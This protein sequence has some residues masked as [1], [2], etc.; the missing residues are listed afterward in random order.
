M[1]PVE[2]IT[3]N[4]SGQRFATAIPTLV[5]KCQY[6]RDFFRSDWKAALQDDGA[7]FVDSN[8]EVF[9][10]ILN[11][12]RR[13]VFPLSYDQ[14]KGH[15][16]K[17][18]AEV[19]AEARHFRIPKLERWLADQLYLNCITSSTVWS[20]AFKDDTLQEGFQTTSTWRSDVIS[21]QLVRNDINVTRRYVCS[22]VTGGR[23]I[24]TKKYCS[25]GAETMKDDL[26]TYRWAEVG[27][28]LTFHHGWCSDT[29]KEF[30]E[31]WE[32]ISR[33]TPPGKS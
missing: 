10:H 5:D 16:Y 32:R 24:C 22:H 13:G 17:L 9:R 33:P 30:V 1:Y 28:S 14:K 23:N 21:T 4:V 19:L 6:F 26:E 15:D 27:K 31:Y 25:V 7:I 29:G 2:Q 18:Y 20:S 3:L 8:P 12:L 11:Y